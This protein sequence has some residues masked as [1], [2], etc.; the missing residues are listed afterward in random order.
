MRRAMI[1]I[2]RNLADDPRAIKASLEL[3][4]PRERENPIRL[5]FRASARECARD[6]ID[7]CDPA[8]DRR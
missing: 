2:R 6:R 7:L 4:Q 3:I 5:G 1:Y 8:V